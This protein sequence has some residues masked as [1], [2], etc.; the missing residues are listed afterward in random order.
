MKIL[1][2]A[3]TD[4]YLYNFRCSLA[5]TLRAAGYEV[6]LVSPP[7]TYGLKLQEMG[8]RWIEIGRAHV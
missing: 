1:L 7:G 3:N 4:W 5:L 6:L 2:F 8:F